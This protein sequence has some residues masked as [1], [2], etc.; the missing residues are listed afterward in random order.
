MIKCI[1]VFSKSYEVVID[2]SW[3]AYSPLAISH[4][5]LSHAVGLQNSVSDLSWVDCT[6]PVNSVSHNTGAT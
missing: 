3:F 6:I 4:V 1:M 2:I 5:V